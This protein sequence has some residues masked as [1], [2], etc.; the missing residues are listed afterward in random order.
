MRQVTRLAISNWLMRKKFRRD[1]T[2]TDGNTLYLYNNAIAK[3]DDSDGL[4]YVRSAGWETKTTRER[5]NGIPG[6]RIHQKNWEWYLNNI[7][8]SHSNEWTPIGKYSPQNGG[9]IIIQ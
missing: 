1:N 5:L 7:L 4:V 2:H 3:I 9:M 8:W 6:V